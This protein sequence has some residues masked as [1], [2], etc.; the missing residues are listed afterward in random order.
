[1]TDEEFE[2]HLPQ[3][4]KLEEHE[5]GSNENDTYIVAELRKCGDGR[6]FRY[7]E[8]SGMDSIY[9]GAG[10]FGEWLDAGEVTKWKVF[11]G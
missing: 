8:S 4:Q 10:E 1:M 6:H 3:A 2:F 5:H 7:I 11:K 9:A